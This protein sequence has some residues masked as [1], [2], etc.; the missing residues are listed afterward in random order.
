MYMLGDMQLVTNN[1]KCFRASLRICF[2]HSLIFYSE[3]LSMNLE[4]GYSGS[5]IHQLEMTITKYQKK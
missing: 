2:G 5:G 4:Q 1:Y 3:I